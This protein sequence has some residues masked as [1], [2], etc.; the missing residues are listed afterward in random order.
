MAYSL[1]AEVFYVWDPA[2]NSLEKCWQQF[3]GKLP[4]HRS[5]FTK[6]GPTR[7]L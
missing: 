3:I 4:S 6:L 1:E 2:A 7:V 5:D